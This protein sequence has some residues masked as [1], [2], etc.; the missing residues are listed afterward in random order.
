MGSF[1]PSYQRV[2]DLS[3]GAIP[4]LFG[5]LFE[6]EANL[7]SRGCVPNTDTN[8]VTKRTFNKQA[9]ILGKGG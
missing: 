5:I 4:P 2:A 1:A 8:I 7:I 9:L 3:L 6:F